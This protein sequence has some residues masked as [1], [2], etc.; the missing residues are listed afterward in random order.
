MKIAFF[1]TFALAQLGPTFSV[2]DPKGPNMNMGFLKKNLNLSL[3]KTEA[4]FIATN[5]VT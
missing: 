4:I 5:Y 1:A 2:L 3:R